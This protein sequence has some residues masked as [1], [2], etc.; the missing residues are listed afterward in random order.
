MQ[1]LPPTIR[2][3]HRGLDIHLTRL[4]NYA[5]AN[6]LIRGGPGARVTGDRTGKVLRPVKQQSTGAASGGGKWDGTVTF[7]RSRNIAGPI[8][9]AG[10]PAVCIDITYEGDGAGTVIYCDASNWKN[11][12][13]HHI[14]MKVSQLPS[15][16]FPVW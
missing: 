12:P 15:G 10:A 4:R 6:A 5:R 7:M 16:T 13:E 3:G 2:T 11:W 14:I 8:T 1:T 9:P